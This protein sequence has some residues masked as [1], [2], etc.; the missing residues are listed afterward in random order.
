MN[1][2]ASYHERRCF[3][4]LSGAGPLGFSSFGIIATVYPEAIPHSSKA[5]SHNNYCYPS[6]SGRLCECFIDRAPGHI[7]ERTSAEQGH[8][9]VLHL[10]PAAPSEECARAGQI[11]KQKGTGKCE[12]HLHSSRSPRPLVSRHVVTVISSAASRAL[13]SAPSEPKSPVVTRSRARLS[14]RP[15]AYSATTSRRTSAPKAATAPAVLTHKEKISAAAVRPTGRAA[16]C[17]ARTGW[18]TQCSRKS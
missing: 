7:C 13:P 14:A 10:V 2:L 3:A 9:P 4:G 18:G 17:R 15:Q 12:R 8:S 6:P 1:P 16:F 11:E 5:A